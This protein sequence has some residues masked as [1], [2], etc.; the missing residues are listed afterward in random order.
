MAKYQKRNTVAEVEA[1]VAPTLEQ[2]GFALWDVRFEKEGGRWFLRYFI[3]KEGGVVT[4]AFGTSDPNIYI[5]V[6]DRVKS[7]GNAFSVTL[8]TVMLPEQMAK[9]L[10]KELKKKIR[11]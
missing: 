8:Q 9:S 5:K 1:L 10:E 4:A 2:L 7:T 6:S 3:D 11:L